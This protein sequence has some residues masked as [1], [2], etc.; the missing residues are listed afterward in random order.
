MTL[1]PTYGQLLAENSRLRAR[2]ADLERALAQ[3]A[4]G[5]FRKD[6]NGIAHRALGRYLDER[7][8]RVLAGLA[9]RETGRLP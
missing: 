2:V 9:E 3:I 6:L 1:H 5:T 7:S 8:L 4:L